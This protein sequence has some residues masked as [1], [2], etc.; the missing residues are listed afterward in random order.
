MYIYVYV[1]N[2]EANQD[3]YICERKDMKYCIYIYIY[4]KYYLKQ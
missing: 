2:D 1:Q 4:I 3:I